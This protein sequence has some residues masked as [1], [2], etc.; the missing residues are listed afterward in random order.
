[1]GDMAARE[2]QDALAA[3]GVLKRLLADGALTSDE[4]PFAAGPGPL[5]VEH[6]GHAS[7]GARGN[8]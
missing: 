3:E 6:A 5:D 8:G 4:G 2:L 7:G 1:M